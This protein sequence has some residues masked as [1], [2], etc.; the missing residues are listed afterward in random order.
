MHKL[1]LSKNLKFRL[2]QMGMIVLCTIV[3]ERKLLLLS[4]R[5][6]LNLNLKTIITKKMMNQRT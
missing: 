1:F 2:K 3:R 5:K 6:I 4:V